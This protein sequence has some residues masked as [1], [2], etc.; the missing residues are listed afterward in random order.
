MGGGEKRGRED[1]KKGR[2]EETW[3]E[4]GRRP[5]REIREDRREGV[6]EGGW[7]EKEI[8]EE[9]GRKKKCRREQKAQKGE[10]RKEGGGGEAKR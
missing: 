1:T 5:A 2:S 9:R 10:G 4:E 3:G 7:R 8:G 6:R